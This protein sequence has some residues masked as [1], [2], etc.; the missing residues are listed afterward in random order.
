MQLWL[1]FGWQN[2]LR[3]L[4]FFSFFK[5]KF[6]FKIIF[7]KFIF[8]LEKILQMLKILFWGFHN[9]EGLPA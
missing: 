4:F 7:Y 8:N 6:I 2:L 5:N 9:V 3:G 1:T